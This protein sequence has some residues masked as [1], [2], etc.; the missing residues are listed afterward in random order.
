[1]AVGIVVGAF[2]GYGWQARGAAPALP[3]FRAVV[4]QC[5][6]A[7]VGVRCVLQADAKVPAREGSGFVFHPAG[8]VLTNAHLLEDRMLVLVEVRDRGRFVAEVVSEDAVTD[9]AVLRLQPPPPA[10]LP[11]LEFGDS[12]QV[13]EGDWVL[14]VGHPLA[15]HHTVTAG[16][17]SH[18]G[19]HFA[20]EGSGISAAYLQF[21]A[22]VNPGS[23]GGP[24]LDA[25]GKVV[26]LTTSKWVGGEGL[27]F[28]V[29]S[30]LVRWVL[31]RMEAHQ[32][33]VPRGYLGVSLAPGRAEGAG[34][35]VTSVEPDGPGWRAGLR[36]GDVVVRFAGE[37][38]DG[39]EALYEKI[40]QALPT[41]AVDVEVRTQA[42]ADRRR[43]VAVLG[44]ARVGSAPSSLEAA[45]TQ[46]MGGP[47]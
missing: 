35:R 40:T 29:P 4:A 25:N 26:G 11:A 3:S 43:L 38:I 7:V 13:C 37:P 28:A 34:A 30:N 33:E 21:S 42:R 45:S 14:T 39:A 36:P 19:R 41:T 2:A 22:A 10:P 47:Y 8:L 16:L 1:M 24:V 18:R 46:P 44:R 9:L 23:S 15:L 5:K 27:A 32:G 12:D 31:A 20:Q 6:D 17:V